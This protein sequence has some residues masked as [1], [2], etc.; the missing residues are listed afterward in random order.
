MDHKK[1]F[2]VKIFSEF[3]S[4]LE[5]IGALAIA[6]RHRDDGLGLIY[7]F[8]TYGVNDKYSPSTTIPDIYHLLSSGNGL[9]DALFLPVFQ[10]N[11]IITFF[12]APLNASQLYKETNISLIQASKV[13]LTD[14]KSL[15]R[16]YNKTKH[17]FIV[18]SH[19][20]IFQ[21]IQEVKNNSAWIIGKNPKYK[22]DL[23]LTNS[24]IE[25]FEV[26]IEDVKKTI[27]RMPVLTGVLADF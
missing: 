3:M 13:Y 11:E 18:T 2:A 1:L 17:G 7:S 27:D 25:I 22:P 26:K 10:E 20:N 19:R 12:G 15:V 24:V 8:L 5:D 9:T 16:A 21:S 23:P 6:I 14:E 4:L